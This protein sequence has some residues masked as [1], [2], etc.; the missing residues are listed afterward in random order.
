MS[1]ETIRNI[2]IVVALVLVVAVPPGGGA[3]A[4]IVLLVLR[5]L[6]VA[7]FLYFGYVMWRENKHKTAW[8]PQRQRA[9]LYAAA[10]LLGVAAA[11]V[12]LL[13]ARGMRCRRSCSWP[14]SEGSDI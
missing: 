7:A 4:G 14:S 3:L 1:R 5:I 10:G 6:L 13:A 9:I 2:C 12:V 11:R 8:L